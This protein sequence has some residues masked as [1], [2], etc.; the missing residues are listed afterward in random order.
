MKI[1]LGWIEVSY[2]VLFFGQSK[3]RLRIWVMGPGSQTENAPTIN[4]F[5]QETIWLTS[6]APMVQALLV[7]LFHSEHIQNVS[8]PHFEHN[9]LNTKT[10]GFVQKWG[11]YRDL[12]RK[13]PHWQKTLEEHIFFQTTATPQAFWCSLLVPRFAAH[14]AFSLQQVRQAPHCCGHC[15]G[16][17]P[18]FCWNGDER[19]PVHFAMSTD[20]HGLLSMFW[21]W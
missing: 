15:I 20:R 3:L 19:R 16:W 7:D 14:A 6:W 5:L 4:P 10:H 18:S 8:A 1:S 11:V 9:M 17:P 21:I 12:R 13:K 2:K